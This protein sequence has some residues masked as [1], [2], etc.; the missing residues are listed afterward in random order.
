[1]S[2]ERRLKL[3]KHIQ[4]QR[5]STVVAYALSDRR[6]AEGSISADAV[7]EIYESLC[8]LRPL[9]KKAL[10]LFICGCGGDTFVPWPLVSMVREMFDLFNVMIPYKALGPA[11]MM[12]L[13]ADT[14]IMGEKGELGPVDVDIPFPHDARQQ[15]GGEVFTAGAADVNGFFS[16][17]EGLGRVREK[18][19]IDA[20]LRTTDSFSPL[21]LGRINK[22]VEQAKSECFKLLESRNRP[23][24]AAA[25]NKIVARLFSDFSSPNQRIS[26][27]EARTYG[28]K[29][30]RQDD[31]LEPVIWE[32]WSLYEEEFRSRDPFYPEDVM[33]ESEEDEVLFQGHKLAYVECTKRTRVHQENV[34]IR[35]I[36][37]NPPDI[38]F[39]PQIVLPSI[40]TDREEVLWPTI[41]D[42]LQ[43]N[44]PLL[45]EERMEKFKKSLPTR[46]YERVHLNKRW[47]DE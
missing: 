30:V 17:L 20:F 23:Y 28:L 11:T 7:R 41:Q 35:R 43:G 10:D 2:K 38:Q 45:I 19:R 42:W 29:H 4:E 12:A 9:D 5:N 25:N 36:R 6:N 22:T 27:K 1:M 34:K 26:R 44:L 47:A 39:D 40:P 31:A 33:E 37:E 24:R 14:I 3:I 16:L 8:A 15:N 21:I 46:G 32:L 18:Q 13:G